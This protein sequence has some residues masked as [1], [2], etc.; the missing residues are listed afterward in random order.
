VDPAN[1]VIPGV[2]V[3]YETKNGSASEGKGDYLKVSKATWN[4]LSDTATVD[5][6]ILDDLLVEN[7]EDFKFELSGFSGPRTGSILGTNPETITIQDVDTYDVSIQSVSPAPVDEA[8]TDVKFT[9]VLA[10]FDTDTGLIGPITVD[11]ETSDINATGGLDYVSV[12]PAA[13]LTFT[14]DTEGVNVTINEDT[15]VE[16]DETFNFTLSNF[17]G[18]RAGNITGGPAIATIQHLRRRHESCNRGRYP[19]HLHIDTYRR[20][21]NP[22]CHRP[23]NG[24][25]RNH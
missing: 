11:Y 22:R 19:G 3:E 15:L 13:T 25:L 1:G 18:A 21:P 7:D 14:A 10:N 4:F 20:G 12:S 23:I 2:S 8:N 24:G 6:Q 9:L 5:V 16:N 17:A